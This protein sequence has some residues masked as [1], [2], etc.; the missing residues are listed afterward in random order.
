MKFVSKS[1]NYLV[2][3]RHSVPPEPITG[4][5][6]IPGLSVR[7]EGGIAVV[8]DEETCKLLMENKDFNNDFH[9]FEDTSGAEP[10]SRSLEPEHNIT[11]L[12]YGTP[13][14]KTSTPKQ[15]KLPK[16]VTDYM[17]KTIQEGI[18]NGIKALLPTL[19]KEAAKSGKKKTTAKKGITIG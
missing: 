15:I 17:T 10:V 7:F 19:I 6:G 12:K 11:E 13:V 4:R 2:V 9:L 1:A 5:L 3:L 16:E 8:K 14:G 18:Q